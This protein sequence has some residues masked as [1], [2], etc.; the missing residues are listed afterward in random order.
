MTELDK[1]SLVLLFSTH[2]TDNGTDVCELRSAWLSV[3]GDTVAI[4][5][6]NCSR[7][8]SMNWDYISVSDF[9]EKFRPFR[10]PD[11]Q[12]L[13]MQQRGQFDIPA[14]SFGAQS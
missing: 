10:Y 3:H 1:F 9:D 14:A 4:K 8:D 5:W 12:L 2:Y 6:L 7:G 11:D 13:A